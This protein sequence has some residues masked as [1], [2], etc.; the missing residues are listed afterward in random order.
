[1]IME[2]IKTIIETNLYLTIA[3]VDETGKFPLVTPLFFANHSNKF[4]WISSCE[5]T[6]SKNIEY[7]PNVSAVIF[8]TNAN[9][10]DGVGVYMAGI[11]NTI[12]DH[13]EIQKI[14][15][16]M[17]KKL[18]IQDNRTPDYYCPPNE[19]R[20]Y[21]FIAEKIWTNTVKYINGQ[22]IDRRLNFKLKDVF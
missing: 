5:S 9:H 4:Y 10:G 8:D 20:M 6:H 1:M 13:E 17:K 3:T 11:V 15:N 2:N 7:N 14:D 16:L 18:N 12:Y 19:R 22:Y 21:Q